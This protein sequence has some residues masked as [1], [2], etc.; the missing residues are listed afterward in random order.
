MDTVL[1]KW[2]THIFNNKQQECVQWI[3]KHGK[4][5][6]I[7]PLYQY[8]DGPRDWLW[9]GVDERDN[10]FMFTEADPLSTMYRAP[11]EW[12][13]SGFKWVNEPWRTI[14]EKIYNPIH[15]VFDKYQV[16]LIE[17]IDNQNE[18]IIYRMEYFLKDLPEPFKLKE[19]QQQ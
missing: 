9:C 11:K 15:K 12:G 2:A 10:L 3:K 13:I 16:E 1:R 18:R 5:V 6:K 17:W 14:P 19:Q 4:C 7:V 8:E